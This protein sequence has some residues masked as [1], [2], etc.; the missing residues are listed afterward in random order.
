MKR[1]LTGIV[2]LA[3]SGCTGDS[4]RSA[5][6]Q[7]PAA[8]REVGNAPDSANAGWKRSDIAGWSYDLLSEEGEI[9]GLQFNDNGSVVA[10][11]GQPGRLDYPALFW[12]LDSNKRLLICDD[13]DCQDRFSVLVLGSVDNNV[14]TARNNISDRVERY[15][16]KP[17]SRLSE[18]RLNELL[19]GR[20]RDDKKM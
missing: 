4:P 2:L 7:L 13:R 18:E 17:T 9:A 14:V 11:V 1:A 6:D 5:S 16:R 20:T 12:S 10:T 19:P 3:I 15:F 8:T